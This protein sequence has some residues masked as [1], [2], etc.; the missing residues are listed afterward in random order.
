MLQQLKAKQEVMG[1]TAP[2][3]TAIIPELPTSAQPSTKAD[4]PVNPHDS[5]PDLTKSFRTH[6]DS[7]YML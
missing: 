2:E 6:E 4:L 3:I 1:K 5:A 7:I